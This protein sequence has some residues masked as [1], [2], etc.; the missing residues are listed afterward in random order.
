MR[1]RGLDPEAVEVRRIADQA[2]AERE[3]FPGSPTIRV[4]GA[5]I[6]PDGAGPAGLLCR[7]YRRVDGRTSPL[8]DPDRVRAALIGA[9]ER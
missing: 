7:V 3:S 2:E 9:D 8:P 5:D 4:D 1:E 6:D